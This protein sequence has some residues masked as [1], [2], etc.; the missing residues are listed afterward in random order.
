MELT[1]STAST[2]ASSSRRA[3][4]FVPSVRTVLEVGSRYILYELMTLFLFTKSDFKTIFFPVAMFSLV[5]ASS[6]KMHQ[7]LETA[8]WVWLFLLQF[9]VSNQVLSPDEDALNKPWRPIPANRISPWAAKRLRLILVPVCLS[10]SQSLGVFGPGLLLTAGIFCNNELY[11]DS[12]WATRNL[13]NALGYFAFESGASS[14]M[15]GVPPVALGPKTFSALRTSTL[16][17]LTTIHAQDFRDKAG[18]LTQG[19]K[20]LPIVAPKW[21]RGTMPVLLILWPILLQPIYGFGINIMM[22]ILAV[23]SAVGARFYLMRNPCD[24]E[25]SYLFYNVWLS[26]IQISML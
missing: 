5:A 1:F 9:C 26:A 19:R 8:I 17:I 6:P 2:S 11:F 15:S 22:F 23:A 20:T 7:I 12:H 16:L 13:A 10:L 18:D 3:L 24:D 21:S 14:I 25:W 4:S